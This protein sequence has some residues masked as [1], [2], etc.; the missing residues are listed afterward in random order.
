MWRQLVWKNHSS[1]TRSPDRETGCLGK[2]K[3]INYDANSPEVIYCQLS[4]ISTKVTMYVYRLCSL[5]VENSV[6]TP[7]PA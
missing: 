7:T 6:T 4:I 1:G 3:W 5:M 2:I